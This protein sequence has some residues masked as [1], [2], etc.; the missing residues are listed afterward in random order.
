M[1]YVYDQLILNFVGDKN[2]K[3]KYKTETYLKWN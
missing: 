1:Q 3:Y 2:K